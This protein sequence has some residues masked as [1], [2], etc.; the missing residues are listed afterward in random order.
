MQKRIFNL[1]KALVEELGL[2]PGVDTLSRWMAHY[3]AEQMTL[4][5]NAVG[6][7]K[8]EAEKQ[9]FE[10]I[11]KL[12]QHRAHYPEGKRPFENFERVLRVLERLDPDNTSP[13]FYSRQPNSIDEKTDAVQEWLNIASGI[14]H[15]A[16][17]WLEYVFHQATLNATDEKTL[18]WLE[19]ARG[20]PESNDIETIVRIL[21][22][23]PP[24][25]EDDFAFQLNEEK[26]ERIESRIRQLDAFVEFSQA[27]RAEFVEELNRT[28]GA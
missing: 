2:D 22:I 7:K 11:L 27:L 14:D 8:G 19:N 17:V 3:I 5:E 16:R 9:C 6:E 12:W 23:R 10:T 18:V 13:H 20:I 26:R 25:G 15:A 4:A 24:N 1:G 28:E 21:E